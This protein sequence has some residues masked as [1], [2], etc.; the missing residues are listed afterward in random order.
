MPSTLGSPGMVPMSNP[1][2]N[3]LG[4]G[5]YAI[6]CLPSTSLMPGFSPATLISLKYHIPT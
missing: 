1:E 5:I 2:Y 6:Q 3:E 4:A